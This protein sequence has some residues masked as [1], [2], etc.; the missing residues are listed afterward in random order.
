MKQKYQALVVAAF[1]VMTGPVWA[2]GLGKLEQDSSLNERF[3]GRIPLLSATADELDSL[4]IGLADHEAFRRADISYAPVLNNLRFKLVE[5]H[6][7]RDYILVTSSEPIREPFLNFLLELSWASGRIYREYTVL[8]DPPLYDRDPGRVASSAST[9]PSA[10]RSIS[11]AASKYSH[12]VIYPDEQSAGT[13]RRTTYGG[14]DYGPVQSGET[15]WSIANDMRPASITTHQMMLALLR[16]NPEAFIGNNINALKRGA[17]L[18][19]PAEEQLNAL[20]PAEALAQ[21]K[22]QRD[23]WEGARQSIAATPATRPSTAGT[24]TATAGDGTAD[25]EGTDGAVDSRL[26]LVAATDGGVSQQAG[27]AAGNN[28]ELSEQ[29][30]L[31]NEKLESLGQENAELKDRLAENEALIED[32]KRL[33]TL[34]D[35]ELAAMQAQV[36]GEFAAAEAEGPAATASLMV[37]GVNYPNGDPAQ[38]I[39]D[40]PG[41]PGVAPAPADPADAREA[42]HTVI[43]PDDTSS[44]ESAAADTAAPEEEPAAADAKPDTTAEPPAK[45]AAPEGAAPDAADGGI[46]ATLMGLLG[47]ARVFIMDN[48]I[49][50]G[51]ALLA[52]ILL[53][54]GAVFLRRRREASAEKEADDIFAGGAF[55]AFASGNDLDQTS[56]ENDAES[57]TELNAAVAA[58]ID[59]EDTDAPTEMGTMAGPEDENDDDDLFV[60]PEGEA[61]PLITPDEEEDP[62]AEVNVLMAYEHFD[63]AESFVRNKLKSEPDN[64]DYQAKL[65]EIFYSAGNKKKYEEAASDLR[66]LTGGQ[67]EHWS[68]AVAMWQELSPNRAL[69]EGSDEDEEPTESVTAG[70]AV[71]IVDI[72]GDTAGD[73][74]KGEGTGG[75]ID[76]DLGD[77]TGSGSGDTG[78]DEMLD[79]TA[80]QEEA[81]DQMLD[82]TAASSTEDSFDDTQTLNRPS[83]ADD[84]AL[85]FSLDG[86]D[87]G[88][89]LDV[90]RSGEI[91]EGED[92]L[93]V[94]SSARSEDD[95]GFDFPLDME[96]AEEADKEQNGDGD[97]LLEFESDSDSEAGTSSGEDYGDNALE[98]DTGADD[99][100]DLEIEDESDNGGDLDEIGEELD[101]LEQTLGTLSRQDT[102]R[103][104]ANNTSDAL[105]G[106]DSALENMGDESEIENPDSDNDLEISLEGLSAEGNES[107]GGELSDSDLADFSIELDTDEGTGVPPVED[108]E[109]SAELSDLNLDL[110][111]DSSEAAAEAADE[112]ISAELS[113]L[114]KQLDSGDLELGDED[115]LSLGDGSD[116]LSM[117]FDLDTGDE[118][119]AAPAGDDLGIS[120]DESDSETGDDLPPDTVKMDAILSESDAEEAL[121]G[122]DLDL[123]LSGD[124]LGSTADID[125]D[126]T[127]ELPKDRLNSG[128][129]LET[130]EEESDNTLFVPRSGD[131]AEQSLEDELTTK[132]DLAKAY[133]EL[134]DSDSARAILKEVLQDGNDDQKRQAE[135]L[136]AQI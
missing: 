17:I 134:G 22:K 23:L 55:P 65:L 33:I 51:G 44:R 10:E 98:F 63:Q 62:L 118:S 119:A 107:E 78:A 11:T 103:N 30:A 31:A 96:S 15:L 132:L 27:T 19:R 100:L 82:L 84:N 46:V 47:S 7:G 88:D 35:N 42:E 112:A 69:F 58:G 21:V 91:D 136:L 86:A 49:M 83:E 28:A 90:T 120:L 95:T 94:T 70:G 66:D 2:L 127:V 57:A 111:R 85:D 52:L 124:N 105:D 109:F 5:P 20:T 104:F 76:F 87:G 128:L 38:F 37:D 3:E 99:E 43:Y 130:D 126:S 89:L 79:L 4:K 125:M 40:E 13:A 74:V 110:D 32:L 73:A 93:D 6:D 34:K 64:V 16:A 24:G 29:M 121:F 92:L 36:A 81:D 97:D 68:M 80:S 9:T 56:F 50:A 1:L 25:D 59:D 12:T 123:D 129:T 101:R 108:D 45:A 133:V 71:G 53:I 75:G 72:T 113:E 117:D 61:E 54:S 115:D 67:G 122:N 8:L 106:I 77:S 26:E 48:L 60:V 135:D 41:P 39:S 131:T 102:T 14:G 116:E 18:Q 114:S